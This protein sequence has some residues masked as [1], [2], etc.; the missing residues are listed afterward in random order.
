MVTLEEIKDVCISNEVYNTHLH[1]F[2]KYFEN[3]NHAECWQIIYGHLDDVIYPIFGNQYDLQIAKL[4]NNISL[5]HYENGNKF[6]E[7]VI[8][9][10]VNDGYF[11]EYRENGN[12]LEQGYYQNGTRQGE[13]F[14]Y[15]N[16]G[17]IIKYR[18]V[19]GVPLALD[20]NDIM[21]FPEWL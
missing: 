7:D 3:G 5:W 18:Y 12:L 20:S 1:P 9:N 6:I 17:I 11:K 2:L 16:N 8:I 21:I 15:N 19:D 14:H 13:W 4:A 10:G